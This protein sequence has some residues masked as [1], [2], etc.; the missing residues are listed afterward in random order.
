MKPLGPFEHSSLASSN[1]YNSVTLGSPGTGSSF[2]PGSVIQSHLSPKNLKPL[3]SGTSPL[4]KQLA[5]LQKQGVGQMVLQP[6]LQT[7]DL[8]V[9]RLSAG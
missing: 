3:T 2:P 9:Q 1:P 6:V 7:S 5:Q 8:Q 4:M